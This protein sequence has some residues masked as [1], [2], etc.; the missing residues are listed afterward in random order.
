MIATIRQVDGLLKNLCES[1][2][3]SLASRGLTINYRY[4]F[5][6]MSYMPFFGCFELQ[7]DSR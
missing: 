2:T 6:F 3:K 7:I 4:D 5:G 1:L